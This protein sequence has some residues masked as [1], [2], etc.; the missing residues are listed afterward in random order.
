MAAGIAPRHR[1]HRYLAGFDLH[2][3]LR[4]TSSLAEAVA[5]ADLVVMGVPSHGFRS[6]PERRAR[7]Y[8]G[9]GA[10]GEP[11]QGARAGQPLKRMTE[12]INEVLPG[13]PYGVLTGPNLAKE[14]MAGDAA[15]A[16]LAMSD[17][18]IAG[19][20]HTLF[21][22][23]LFRVYTNPDVVGCEVAGAL[24]NVMAIAVGHGRR[25][26]HRRQHPGR[27]DH[28]RPGRAD[29]AGRGHGRPG[30]HLQR[31][32]R[33]GRPGGH[34]HLERQSRNRYVGEQ[35]GRGRPIDEIIA[36]MRWSP[37]GSRRASVVM[38]L[39]EQYG[40]EMPIAEQVAAVV[41]GVRTAA[42]II[43]ALMTREATSE[44]HGMASRPGR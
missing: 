33:H 42:E 6:G 37:R 4:A 38:E 29:P 12:V 7:A 23:R 30:H 24:K 21:A 3:R 31:A 19:E 9:V 44:W 32:G 25:P 13:H 17:D 16:V 11:D 35:L 39:A 34:L 14:I 15:A 18:T 8:V 36:E 5:Q 41:N 1:N 22:T 2:P 20:L 28:P 43:P 10:G 26:G 27:G 40:V